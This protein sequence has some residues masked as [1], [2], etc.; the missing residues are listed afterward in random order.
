VHHVCNSR[1]KDGKMLF[2][3]D[4]GILTTLSPSFTIAASTVFGFVCVLFC[5]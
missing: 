4:V 3:S 5:F 1:N 2:F